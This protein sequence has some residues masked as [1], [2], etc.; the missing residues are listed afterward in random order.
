MG[1]DR[2][3]VPLGIEPWDAPGGL[4]LLESECIAEVIN[5]DTHE[6][7]AAG[8]LG[9]LVI[10]NLGRWGQPVIRYRTWRPCESCQGT[11]CEWISPNAT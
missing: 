1:D 11:M 3:S 4:L 8:E 7:A 6:P 2:T 10:T 9:E 5:P